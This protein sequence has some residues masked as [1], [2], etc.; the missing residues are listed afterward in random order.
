MGSQCTKTPLT[1]CATCPSTLSLWLDL[2]SCAP[3]SP[4]LLVRGRLRRVPTRGNATVWGCATLKERASTGPRPIKLRL[5]ASQQLMEGGSE[6]GGYWSISRSF[7]STGRDIHPSFVGRRE[8]VRYQCSN[9]ISL[10]LSRAP[11]CHTGSEAKWATTGWER[12]T[13]QSRKCTLNRYLVT[14]RHTTDTEYTSYVLKH[15][16]KQVWIDNR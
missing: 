13:A 6:K 2:G 7:S 16:T 4:S 14:T 12:E 3:I 8:S 1:D 15:L 10:A 5:A 9:V 11:E